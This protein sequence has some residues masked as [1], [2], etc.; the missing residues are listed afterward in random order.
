MKDQEFK[1][2]WRSLEEY[3]GMPISADFS[4]GGFEKLHKI[5]YFFYSYVFF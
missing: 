5:G 1:D 3:P 4:A 2:I